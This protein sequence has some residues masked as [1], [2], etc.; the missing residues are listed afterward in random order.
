MPNQTVQ[1]TGASRFAQRQTQPQARLAP[2]ADLF[3]PV[4]HDDRR[5]TTRFGFT[6]VS[7]LV[8]HR[9]A[10]DLLFP[11]VRRRMARLGQEVSQHG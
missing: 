2:V 7:S 5:T 4:L 8:H 6:L 3:L 11:F 1:R 9:L 10:G